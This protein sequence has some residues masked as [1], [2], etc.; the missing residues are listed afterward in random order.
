MFLE[1]ILKEYQDV[2][3]IILLTDDTDKTIS[4][5]KKNGLTQVGDYNCVAFM[6]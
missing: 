6:K 2:R 4:F 1:I 5:Y 3:Q